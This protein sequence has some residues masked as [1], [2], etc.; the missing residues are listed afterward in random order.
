MLLR[1]KVEC[2]TAHFIASYPRNSC[3]SRLEIDEKFHKTL[4]V[5]VSEGQNQNSCLLFK[6]YIFQYLP[7]SLH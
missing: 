1:E 5:V 3:G 7:N 2:L 6:I 4:T